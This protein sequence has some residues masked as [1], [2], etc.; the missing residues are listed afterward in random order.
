M[1]SSGL[2]SFS[3]IRPGADKGHSHTK[4][5]IHDNIKIHAIHINK[6]KFKPTNWKTLIRGDKK[7]IHPNKTQLTTT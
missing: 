1:P 5:K 2:V 7:Q 6:K 4:I 3:L